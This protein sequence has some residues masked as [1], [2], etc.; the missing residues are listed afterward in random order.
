[1]LLI[2][3]SKYKSLVNF[4]QTISIVI[5]GVIFYRCISSRCKLLKLKIQKINYNCLSLGD[6]GVKKK[7]TTSMMNIYK[8]I[9]GKKENVYVQINSQWSA[10][11]QH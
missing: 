6:I 9:Y 10:Q 4:C 11:Q 5:N 3:D 2:K 8:G 1:M 7:K